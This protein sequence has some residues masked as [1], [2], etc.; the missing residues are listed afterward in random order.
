VGASAKRGSALVSIGIILF[1]GCA[2]GP[3]TPAARSD[4]QSPARHASGILPQAKGRDLLY[5]TANDLIYVYTYPRG[6]LVGS[7]YGSGSGDP[8]GLCVDS[9]GNVYVTFEYGDTVEYA[10]GS[11]EPIQDWNVFSS[12][13]GCSVDPTTGNLAV[14]N[15]QNN[16]S[17]GKGFVEVWNRATGSGQGYSY[18]H[19]SEPLW[20]GYDNAGNLFIEGIFSRAGH[21]H[22]GLVELPKGGT[23]LQNI[24]VKDIAFG[25]GGGLTG[26]QYDGK[27]LTIGFSDTIDQLRIRR[28]KA[29]VV[30]TT[31]ISTPSGSSWSAENYFAVTRGKTQAAHLV[32]PIG[33]FVGFFDYPSGGDA[34]K[35]CRQTSP[36]SAVVSF[37]QK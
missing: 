12:P 22:P 18:P 29:E 13:L 8:L 14:A 25:G 34:T 19:F 17:G 7:F 3:V 35:V 6:K 20:C 31:T 30:G 26:V 4:V 32:A 10:H 5:V 11:T 1:A 37:A 33:P 23:A 21:S 28:S 16:L 2:G 24:N 36:V 27:H 15:P 9:G